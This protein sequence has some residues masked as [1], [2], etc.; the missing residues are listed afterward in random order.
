MFPNH[1][2]WWS[3]SL[4]FSWRPCSLK[5]VWR[6]QWLLD[7]CCTFDS[8]FFE[9]LR[10]RLSSNVTRVLGL[11]LAGDWSWKV[12]EKKKKE[13]HQV[14]H[15]VNGMRWRRL[16]LYQNTLKWYCSVKAHYGRSTFHW[17]FLISLLMF[18][19]SLDSEKYSWIVL[20]FNIDFLC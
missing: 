13:W 6:S 12:Q 4:V 10:G 2:I 15:K 17:T 18:F 3:E 14:I 20:A 19:N 5:R 9:A 1:L 11:A 8:S 7:G 16:I